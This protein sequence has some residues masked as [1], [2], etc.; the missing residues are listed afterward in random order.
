MRYTDFFPD[1]L[2]PDPL[3]RDPLFPKT[4]KSVPHQIQNRYNLD[5]KYLN[6]LD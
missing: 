2:F 4:R 1:P 5:S 6:R 3:F